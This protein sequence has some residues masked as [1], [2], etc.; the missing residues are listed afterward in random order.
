MPK[1]KPFKLDKGAFTRQAKAYKLTI[2]QFT[3]I[4]LKAHKNPDAY[5]YKPQM[6]TVRR[7]QFAKNIGKVLK[8][9]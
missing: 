9:K 2:P 1:K 5:G 3:R 4:V 7:A 6:T 8:K